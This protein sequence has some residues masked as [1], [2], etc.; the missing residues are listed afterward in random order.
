MAL[1]GSIEITAP[2]ET[3]GRF[4]VNAKSFAAS[5]SEL[6]TTPR[7]H[8]GEGV[9]VKF[10][11]LNP[12]NT[13]VY[14]YLKSLSEIGGIATND[15][16]IYES[17]A[18][19]FWGSM[20]THWKKGQVGDGG[21]GE[22][23]PVVVG[24]FIKIEL[25]WVVGSDKT[26]KT[27]NLDDAIV[28][29]GPAH[30]LPDFVA[31]SIYG[32]YVDKV[33]Q[34][35]GEDYTFNSRT[36]TFLNNFDAETTGFYLT[37]GVKLTSDPGDTGFIYETLD[38]NGIPAEATGPD[39][40][41]FRKHNDTGYEFRE[42][43]PG[44]P[45]VTSISGL[46]PWSGSITFDTLGTGKHRYA[47]HDNRIYET[48]VNANIGNTPPI[49]PDGGGIYQNGFWKEISPS[50][51]GHVQGTDRT[52]KLV[53]GTLIDVQIFYD[54]LTYYEAVIHFPLLYEFEDKYKRA[55]TISEI[56][57][58]SGI[59]TASYSINGG[60]FFPLSLP[61]GA[62]INIPAGANVIWKVNTFAVGKNRGTILIVGKRALS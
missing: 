23:P 10:D 55:V 20:L 16:P 50:Q 51:L 13:G 19:P 46:I 15:F 6:L 48:K 60:S 54:N 4:P 44:E 5:L 31:R 2:L 22:D 58:N 12:D 24:E 32:V 3:K 30:P 18:N 49:T 47:V 42:V 35:L 37:Y 41:L 28:I 52:V 43:E 17:T 33:I 39:Q 9:Y 56:Q 21:G 36:I 27:F 26:I 14:Y 7:P 53:D 8:E 62:P 25:R 40:A 57:F 34:V 29:E 61:L 45:P 59:G 1:N 38:G 11:A